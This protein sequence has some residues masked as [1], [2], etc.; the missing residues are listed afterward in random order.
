MRYAF[1]LSLA[2]LAL[3]APAMAE[4]SD[5]A[6]CTKGQQ[7]IAAKAADFHGETMIRQLIDADLTRAK[8]EQA[9]G[10]ADEC[11]EAL[12]HAGKLLRGE[13]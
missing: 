2:V 13:Y 5:D 1:V 6:S 12:D 4:D 10:D 9:E 3:S 11:L 7:E 8:R